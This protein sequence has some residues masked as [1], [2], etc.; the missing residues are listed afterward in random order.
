MSIFDGE[1]DSIVRS[2]YH[3]YGFA[4]GYSRSIKEMRSS[5]YFCREDFY[6]V[7]YKSLK[8]NYKSAIYVH[9]PYSIKNNFVR[10]IKIIEKKLGIK[11]LFYR[12][13]SCRKPA[14]AN[15]YQLCIIF[16]R[17]W[18]RNSMRFSFFTSLLKAFGTLTNDGI[19]KLLIS[20]KKNSR[21]AKHLAKCLMDTSYFDTGIYNE[22]IVGKR[23]QKAIEKFL[24]KHCNIGKK[25]VV[26]SGGGW[27]YNCDRK[28]P[29]T[30]MLLKSKFKSKISTN[31]GKKN[32]Y[33]SK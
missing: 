1:V 23:R 19:S 6:R 26:S 17:F 21:S 4:L 13:C 9:L 27:L 18:C 24:T 32:V 30:Q 5:W 31:K 25:Y 29:L 28:I 14:Q 15:V 11:S 16:D 20:M 33:S 22:V 12:I 7:S 3:P 8:S 10:C 2:F